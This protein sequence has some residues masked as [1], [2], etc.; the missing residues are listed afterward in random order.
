[1][2]RTYDQLRE[3][4]MRKDYKFFTGHYD[5]NCIWERT[6]EEFTN[7]FTDYFHLAYDVHGE[8][9]VLTIPATTKPGLK[10]SVLSPITSGGLTGTDIIVPGQ[11]A[12]AWQFFDVADLEKLRQQLPDKQLLHHYPFTSPHFRQVKPVQYWRDGNKDLVIDHVG[13][14]TSV[15]GT[16][17]HNMTQPGIVDGEVNNW[18][19]GCMGAPEPELAKVLPIV[20]QSVNIYGNLFTGT[21]IESKDI[22]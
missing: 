22:I 21:I 20:R 7:R 17:W 16:H 12:G 14:H 11:Y 10:G 1:M 4:L 15:D 5:L 3:A 2:R 19:L 8:K 6:S 13:D 9:K 18:S